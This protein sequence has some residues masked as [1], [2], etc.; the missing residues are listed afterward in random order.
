MLNLIFNLVQ[1]KLIILMVNLHLNFEFECSFAYYSF[2]I[3]INK[4]NVERNGIIILMTINAV[5]LIG[6]DY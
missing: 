6:F 3:Y 2:F 5:P 1:Y 4:D